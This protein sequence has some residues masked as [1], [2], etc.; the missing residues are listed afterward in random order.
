[1]KIATEMTADSRAVY[2]RLGKAKIG[3]TVTYEELKALTRRDV[4]GVDRYIL[5]TAL[6]N[7]LRDGKVF[8][9][10]RTVGVKL[11]NDGEIISDAESVAPRIRRISRRASRRLTAVQNFDKLPNEQKVKH[12]AL[13]SVFGAITAMGRAKSI[14]RVEQEV[15]RTSQS[16]SLSATLE[17]FSND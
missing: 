16:L 8:G 9:C 4:Q 13:L 1:M 7:A 3:D 6:K 10:V 14:A 5:N 17:V 11:L 12:N 2:E 15:K